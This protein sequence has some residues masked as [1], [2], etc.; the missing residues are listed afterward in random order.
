MLIICVVWI[1][2]SSHSARTLARVP[3]DC[4][5]AAM[6][7]LLVRHGETGGNAAR[8]VQRP[9]VPLNERGIQQAEQLALRLHALG[10][11]HVLCSDLLRA[12]MTAAPLARRSGLTIE[13]TSL[14]QERNFGDL[15]GT[16]YSELLEDPFTPNY[17]PPNGE[18]V[19]VF[20]R[21]VAAAFEL[22]AARRRQLNGHLVVVT[23]G[24]VCSAILER[25]SALTDGPIVVERYE[26][27][28]LSI[29]GPDAPH[30]AS[31]VNCVQHLGH[32]KGERG[33]PA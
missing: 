14:L 27:T 21:R 3:S 2:Q 15:R 26:N 1:A 28:G 10:F 16:P 17:E 6:S 13:S 22:I 11:E 8:I 31:L 12:Q 23:H 5:N 24:L 32:I 30:L 20:H 19:P 25:H 33:G 4:Y 7:I 29:L 18:S 9:D